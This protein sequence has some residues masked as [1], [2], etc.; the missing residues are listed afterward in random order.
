MPVNER[1]KKKVIM[2]PE[3]SGSGP[4]G[5]NWD[6]GLKYVFWPE[7]HFN[8]MARSSGCPDSPL[9]TVVWDILGRVEYLSCGVWT[10]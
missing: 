6:I 3:I 7:R 5:V 10:Q 1:P 4:T 9:L 8:P 2:D